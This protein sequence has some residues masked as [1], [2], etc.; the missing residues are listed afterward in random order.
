MQHAII[1]HARPIPHA[2]RLRATYTDA[3]NTEILRS[4]SPNNADTLMENPI[5]HASATAL[6]EGETKLISETFNYQQKIETVF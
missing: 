5:S 4:Y 2:V 6:C 3:P 1:I